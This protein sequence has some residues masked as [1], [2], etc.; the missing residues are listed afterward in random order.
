MHA[1]RLSTAEE[2]TY[3]VVFVDGEEVVDGLTAWADDARIRS[4]RLTGI[5]GFRQVT[6]AP[7]CRAGTKQGITQPQWPYPGGRAGP[8]HLRHRRCARGDVGEQPHRR[9]GAWPRA[10]IPP[11][12]LPSSRR[13]GPSPA[14]GI[15]STSPS[16]VQL[17]GHLGQTH[18]GV[19]TFADQPAELHPLIRP[20]GWGQQ[21][22][23]RTA[24]R[25]EVPRAGAARKARARIRG[26]R[27]TLEPSTNAAYPRP[28]K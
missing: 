8:L 12:G 20:F 19:G 10:L 16:R 5:G 23:G 11:P 7:L 17:G 26:S 18:R 25:P 24:P 21:V 4:A 22:G 13:I 1:M 27:E 2:Q 3:V 6:L 9:C 15:C 14:T 28:V